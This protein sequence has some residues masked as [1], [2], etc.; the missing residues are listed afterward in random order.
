MFIMTLFHSLHVKFSFIY[1]HILTYSIYVF[2]SENGGRG[3]L[4]NLVYGSSSSSYMDCE[5][6][7]DYECCR[8][9]GLGFVYTSAPA[10][11]PSSLTS[12]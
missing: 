7:F 4:M 12:S 8:F 1:I 10:S 5:V 6:N 11:A 2:S 3:R 9:A